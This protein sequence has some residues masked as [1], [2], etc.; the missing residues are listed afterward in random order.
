MFYLGNALQSLLRDIDFSLDVRIAG[1]STW[2]SA[3]RDLSR[4]CSAAPLV[5]AV[6]RMR[7]QR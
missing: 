6:F 4:R 7:C 2:R 3:T 5:L 1:S